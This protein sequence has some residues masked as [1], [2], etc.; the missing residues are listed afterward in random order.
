MAQNEIAR[1]DAKINYL[2]SET[3]GTI[4]DTNNN[5]QRRYENLHKSVD[6]AISNLKRD[7]TEGLNKLKVAMET[8]LKAEDKS[9]NDQITKAT[10]QKHCDHSQC[11]ER[12]DKG[13]QKKPV[14]VRLNDTHLKKMVLITL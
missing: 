10:E 7:Q 13:K 9:L 14:K 4:T 3:D 1:K 6:T 12:Y 8:E 11:E 2:K 5:F